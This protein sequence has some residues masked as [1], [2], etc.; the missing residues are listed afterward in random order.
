MVGESDREMVARLRNLWNTL[1]GNLEHPMNRIHKGR[2]K[3]D[4]HETQFIGPAPLKWSII[5]YC[6]VATIAGSA[7]LSIANPGTIR[8]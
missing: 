4:F 8:L 5:S 7:A 6:V 1:K 3:V 2:F